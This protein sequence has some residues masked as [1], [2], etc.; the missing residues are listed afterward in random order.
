M[1]AA[2][3]AAAMA[4]VFAL[5][6]ATYAPTI[7]YGFTGWDDTAYVANNPHVASAPEFWRIWTS[8]DSDVY[9]PLTY[10]SYW[11]EYRLWGAVPA[12]YHASNVVLHGL[13]AVLVLC[14]VLALGTSLRSAALAAAA[15][16]V[17]PLQVMTVAWIAERKNLLALSFTLLTLLAWIRADDGPRDRVLRVL[18]VVLFAA[19]IASKTAVLGLPL[20]LLAYDV[21][22]RRRSGSTSLPWAVPMVVVSIVA[23]FLTVAFER[24]FVGG[25]DSVLVPGFAERLQIAG[26]APWFYVSKILLPSNLSP[27]YPRWPV[28]AGNILWWCPA[29]ATL[30]AIAGLAFLV[31]K[32]PG[33]RARRLAW[34]AMLAAVLLAPSLGIVAFAN[35]AVSFVSDHFLYLPSVAIAGLLGVALD[36]G[37]GET[38]LRWRTTRGAVLAACLACAGATLAYEPVFRDP[39]SMWSRVVRLSPD[40]YAGNLG[41]AESADAAGRTAEA[42]SRYERAIAVEPRAPDAYLLWGRSKKAQGDAAGAAELYARALELSPDS[43]PAMVGL[44]AASEQQGAA[45][46]ALELYERA[47]RTEPRDVPARLGLGAMYLGYARPEDALSQFRVVI[48]IV[49][50]YPRGYL[51]A[52]TSLR[53]LS[54]YAEAVDVL[55]SG[56][57]RSPDDPTLLNLLALTL[58]TAPDDRVRNGASAIPLAERAL[59]VMSGHYEPR[60]TLAAAYAEAGRFEDAVRESRRA[61]ADAGAAHDDRSEAEQRRRSELYAAGSVLRIGR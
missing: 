13:N 8:S 31:R 40:S 36:A 60:A 14:L 1:N 41:L 28:G 6:I 12:G 39:E 45:P 38:S 34:L 55:R 7:G 43:V 46:K 54:R 57:A 20:A 33:E 58:A 17:H 59:T 3:R 19:A 35:L 2:S 27:A 42:R 29:L 32:R 22:V 47:V 11:L 37:E 51:G 52:A 21:L 24:P 9:Y 5:A 26:A 16:A 50:E 48:A 10:S 23:A 44:A 56:L 61:E 25:G 30:S 18:A 53:S 4:V 15:F 49:P